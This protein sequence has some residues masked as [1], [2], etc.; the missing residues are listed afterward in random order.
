MWYRWNSTDLGLIDMFLINLNTEIDLFRLYILF[1][2]YRSCD[3]TQEIWSFV[4][5]IKKSIF[6]LAFILYNEQDKGSNPLS[7]ITWSVL[8]KQNV[9]EKKVYCCLYII[10]QKIA[11]PAKSGKYYQIWFFPRFWG[12]NGG[13][14]SM[15]M[16]VIL[17]FR[18]PGFSP[19]M[20]REERRV[21]GL[22]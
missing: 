6:M 15:R 11:P 7:I 12:E 22:D 21:Q 18:P 5:F 2:Q 10:I 19:Y 1:S 16:Q 17:F 13:V 20:K 4:L 9:Q 3:N 14:L 8:G